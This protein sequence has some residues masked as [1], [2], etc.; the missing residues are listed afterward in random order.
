MKYPVRV[1]LQALPAGIPL[2]VQTVRS[3]TDSG[4]AYQGLA[5]QPYSRSK[6]RYTIGAAALIPTNARA[7]RPEKLPSQ[8]PIVQ[9]GLYP[10]A[11]ASRWS[12]DVP[13]FSATVG[14]SLRAGRVWRS[15]SATK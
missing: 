12:Y 5:P 2:S 14:P 9:S 6:M 1:V 7:G 11:Q 4:S 8:T 10:T 15:A 13:V 3:P